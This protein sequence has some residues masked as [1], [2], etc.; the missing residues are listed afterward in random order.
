MKHAYVIHEYPPDVDFQ[1]KCVYDLLAQRHKGIN[2][3]GVH[4]FQR[5][6]K[7]GGLRA[8]RILNLVWLYLLIPLYLILQ[9]PVWVL[10]GSTPPGIQ[11]WVAFWAKLCRIPSIAWLMDYHPEIEARALEGR[12]TPRFFPKMLRWLDRSCHK[13]LAGAITLDEAM[14]KV[15]SKNNPDVPLRIHPTWNEKCPGN[16]PTVSPSQG[17]PGSQIS[18]AYAGNLG[19]LHQLEPFGKLLD[20][21]QALGGDIKIQLHTFGVPSNKDLQFQRFSDE[22]NIRL[23]IH[24][25]KTHA[26]LGKFLHKHKINYGIVLLEDAAEGVASPSKFS[27]YI[28]AGVPLLYF[29]PQDSNAHKICIDFNAGLALPPKV[30]KN[31]YN[32]AAQSILDPVTREH[33]QLATAEAYRYFSSFDG[34]SFVGMFQSL[35]EEH[36]KKHNN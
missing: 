27:G 10:V 23:S 12:K 5:D 21:I 31:L 16:F 14:G 30:I 28:Y 9:R 29:G 17:K 34:E 18:L 2:V 20:E 6:Y 7:P 1:R 13:G 24:R 15:F 3:Q 25:S 26:E 36:E 11:M 22:H 8:G 35:L 4:G 19:S 33:H 32:G